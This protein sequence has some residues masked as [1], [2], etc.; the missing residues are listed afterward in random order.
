M[1]CECIMPCEKAPPVVEAV[2]AAD[3]TPVPV[4]SEGAEDGASEGA[5]VGTVDR[6]DGDAV[7][8]SLGPLVEG[9]AVGIAER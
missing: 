9:Y 3:G 6:L 2:G 4:A 5:D 8:S 1:R 7:G